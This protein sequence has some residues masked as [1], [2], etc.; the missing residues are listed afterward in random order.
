MKSKASLGILWSFREA[1]GGQTAE[2]VTT[3]HGGIFLEFAVLLRV[4]VD[5]FSL[6]MRVFNG[7]WVH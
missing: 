4:V 2:K 7:L 1:T 5:V 6:S 3:C